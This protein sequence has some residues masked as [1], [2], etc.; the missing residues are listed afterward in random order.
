M[1]A[2]A[3]LFVGFLRYETV[4]YRVKK[5]FDEDL[6]RDANF[7]VSHVR[8]GQDTFSI[9]TEGLSAS[10]NFSLEAMQAYCV[11][12][13]PKGQV[14]QPHLHSNYIQQM[15]K[16][17]TLRGVLSRSDG[18]Q[19]ALAPDG[20]AFRFVSMR[21]G[22]NGINCLIH[23][24]R[25]ANA[26]KEVLHEYLVMYLTSVPVILGISAAVGWFLAGRALKPF[27]EVA[28]TA[29]RITSNSLHTQ[30]T[31]QYNEQE[32]QRL[33][34]AF[35]AMVSRLAS[36]FRQIKTF[37]ADVA[38]ELRTP[39][40]VLQSET[41][42]ALQSTDLPEDIRG[43]LCSNL[44]ELERLSQIIRDMLILA[45]AETGTQILS[46][47]P[48]DIGALVAD[49]VEQM[50][51]LAEVRGIQIVLLRDD[52]AL[53]AADELWMRRAFLNLLDNAIKYSKDNGRVD[54]TVQSMNSS[55]CVKV[56]D[57]GIGIGPEDL[58]HIFDRMYR[59]D[60][61]RSRR[62]GGTGLGLAIVKSVVEA[63]SGTIQVDSRRDAGSTFTVIFPQSDVVQSRQ[64]V[65]SA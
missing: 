24:G 15:L 60:P 51:I 8:L 43:V 44:E 34:K 52:S 39:L 9:A 36:S 57:E 53:V 49:L 47:Q 6:L 45:E 28:R 17:G 12:T 21:S 2:L 4:S 25:N 50:R 42:A 62:T 26:V 33:V 61:A 54:V 37:N 46:K 59:A 56:R 65:Q 29:E 32:V 22:E 31:S 18:V 55:V 40:S 14:F 13:D 20:T 23:V 38:H 7:F 1:L 30:I 3:V 10:E 11:V 35:N 64:A 58:P 16:A 5:H 63:H 27:E 41:E 48:V 19:D